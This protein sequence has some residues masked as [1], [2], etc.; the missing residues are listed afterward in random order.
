MINGLS[1]LRIPI[2][3][4]KRVMG[5][6]V[7]RHV[8]S[9]SMIAFSWAN[10]DKDAKFA[11]S[12][13]FCLICPGWFA[14]SVLTGWLGRA[15]ALSSLLKNCSI[16]SNSSRALRPTKP[17]LMSRESIILCNIELQDEGKLS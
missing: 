17:A 5:S 2:V 7:A 15:S 6:A 3:E 4:V 12:A 13:G 1:F 14:A 16:W 10:K 11:A 8:T 9:S